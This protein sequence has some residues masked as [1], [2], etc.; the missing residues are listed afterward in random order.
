M[1][2]P[3]LSV[4]SEDLLGCIVE[5]VAKLSSRDRDLQ[6]LSL[7]DRA[8]THFCQKYL[9]QTLRLNGFNGKISRN[10]EK[11][12]KILKDNPSLAKS[13]RVVQLS[14]NNQNKWLCND[15][16]LIGVF[17]LIADSPRPPHELYVYGYETSSVKI[18]DP[19]LIVERFAQSFFSETLTTL[20]LLGCK[21]VPLPFLIICPQ[22]VE[23]KLDQVAAT[24]QGYDDYPDELCS[25]R[26]PPALEIFNYRRAHSLVSQMIS[27]PPRFSTPLV[28]WSSLRVLTLSPHEKKEMACLQ[29][30]LDAACN[31]LEELFLTR[32]RVADSCRCSITISQ[33]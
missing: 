23:V 3:P 4:L 33:N 31:T 11:A 26:K 16:I 20:S 21:N 22:L 14:I 32:M 30:I 17:Q 27:P 6:N 25:G 13:V 19:I 2:N 5:H 29:S 7:S 15:P 1:L 28:L 10:I 24:K 8:F 18:E 9:F 12:G